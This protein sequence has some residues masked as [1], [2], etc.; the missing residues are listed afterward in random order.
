MAEEGAT[1]VFG[2]RKWSSTGIEGHVHEHVAE[3]DN[4]S[5][6]A[7]RVSEKQKPSTISGTFITLQS[8]GKDL[9]NIK[10][11]SFGSESERISTNSNKANFF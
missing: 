11:T 8:V 9:R 6:R 4:N 2:M 10:I 7:K 3:K 1:L 5:R